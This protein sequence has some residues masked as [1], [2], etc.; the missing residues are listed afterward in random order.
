VN[1]RDI[2]RVADLNLAALLD[3]KV[4]EVK[5]AVA[6][7]DHKVETVKHDVEA[8]SSHAVEIIMNELPLI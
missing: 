8:T 1:E 7:L 2:A 3:H 6:L 4:E 5:F